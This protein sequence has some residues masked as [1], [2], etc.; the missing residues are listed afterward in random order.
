MRNSLF[1][2]HQQISTITP[3]VA[4]ALLILGL[5]GQDCIKLQFEA[6]A[7]GG[8]H[9]LSPYYEAGRAGD[10]LSPPP[11]AEFDAA[12]L[13]SFPSLLAAA[14]TVFI[15]DLKV[16]SD[17]S[18][19]TPPEQ[20]QFLKVRLSW[21]H[22]S[23]TARPFQILLLT[24]EVA[25]LDFKPVGFQPG[26][27]LHDGVAQ[28]HAGAGHVDGLDFTLAFPDR[29]VQEIRNLQQIWAYLFAQSEADTVRRLKLD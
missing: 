22:E 21:G 9:S 7:E 27:I 2:S 3:H 19:S 25:V 26:D 10:K 8:G 6:S 16:H 18:G 5:I 11:N 23:K 28:T 29:T 15:H 12:L 13:L 24:N 17:S 1:H 20:T 14:D 4:K